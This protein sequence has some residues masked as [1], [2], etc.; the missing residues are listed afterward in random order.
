MGATL[1]LHHSGEYYDSAAP[2]SF[3]LLRY[4][5]RYGTVPGFPK[6]MPKAS[7]GWKRLF[8]TDFSGNFVTHRL[9]Q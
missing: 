7:S 6:S 3:A 2:P 1:Q 5:L 9:S 4:Q 8:S